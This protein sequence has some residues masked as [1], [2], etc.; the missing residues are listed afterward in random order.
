MVCITIQNRVNQKDKA[1]GISFRRKDQLAGV[2]IWSVY[3]RVSKSNSRFNALDMLVVIV[4]TVRMP[5]GFSRTI[6]A[7]LK[8]SVVGV[9]AEDTFLSHALIIPVAK[10]DIDPNYKSYR[11]GREIRLVVRKLFDTIG[12]DLPRV[13]GF[14]NST[15]FKNTLGL[16]IISM[17]MELL[18]FLDSVSSLVH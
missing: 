15:N 16:K 3:E 11:D 14:P 6:V 17:K 18:V 4:L 12:I 1:I 10:L 7:H 9:K 8:R 5:V 13:G 2:V